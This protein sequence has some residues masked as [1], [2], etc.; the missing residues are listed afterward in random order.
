MIY[1]I[2]FNEN[3]VDSNMHCSTAKNCPWITENLVLT[4]K[5]DKLLTDRD[6][7]NFQMYDIEIARTYISF[8]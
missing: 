8:S 7:E 6:R 5:S 3:H 1:G 4:Y 2:G